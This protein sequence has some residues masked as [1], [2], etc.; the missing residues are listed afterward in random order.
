MGI[1]KSKTICEVKGMES[2]KQKFLKNVKFDKERYNQLIL[3][4]AEEAIKQGGGFDEDEIYSY[5]VHYGV[6]N[7]QVVKA[8]DLQRFL[9]RVYDYWYEVYSYQ[10]PNKFTGQMRDDILA[11]KNR[12]TELT[13]EYV[14]DLDMLDFF[15]GNGAFRNEF[16]TNAPIYMQGMFGFFDKESNKFVPN[17]GF[18]HCYSV[19]RGSD[20]VKMRLYLNIKG[21]N[22]VALASLLYGTFLRDTDIPYC[23]K[24]VPISD[25]NDTLVMYTSYEN[26]QTCIDVINEVRKNRPELFDGAENISPL[27]GKIDG[28]I[29]FG[30]EP[31]YRHSSFNSERECIGTMCREEYFKTMQRILD[32]TSIRLPN[33]ETVFVDEYL[34]SVIR[35]HLVETISNELDKV[36]QDKYVSGIYGVSK[37]QMDKY[38]DS[39]VQGQQE[40]IE[41]L[42]DDRYFVDNVKDLAQKYKDAILLKECKET[43]FTNFMMK[44]H[45]YAL[46]D[47]EGKKEYAITKKIEIEDI[48]KELLEAVPSEK[49]AFQTRILDPRVQ[50]HYYAKNHVSAKV[51]Y[52]NIESEKELYKDA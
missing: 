13:P 4:T 26:A 25:R 21:E 52:L 38:F 18:M 44:R 35:K 2:A 49:Q 46:R 19:G 41:T 45:E 47:D 30:E 51:P 36:C 43:I 3:D 20:D 9:H 29:G 31:E 8:E 6:E 33:G 39:Y 17:G 5:L 14:K 1:I 22:I 11:V 28:Y 42:K 48:A 24:F 27:L 12:T 40:L 34:E 32:K 37:V 23:F 10:D 7:P 15:R 16:S 50:A